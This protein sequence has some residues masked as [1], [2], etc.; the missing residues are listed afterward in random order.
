V[1]LEREIAGLRC[2][3]VL[4][5]LSQ[6]L[7]G[8]LSA[9]LASRVEQHVLACDWCRKFG[10]EFAAVVNSLREKLAAPEP[11]EERKARQLWSGLE[12]RL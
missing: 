5:M 2:S 12:A 1:E 9:D 4:E 7:D 8:E 6:Y 10:A 3:Q 11:L